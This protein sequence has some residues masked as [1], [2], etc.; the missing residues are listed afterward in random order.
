MPQLSKVFDF[1]EQYK[2][3]EVGVNA[4]V[5]KFGPRLVKT[6]GRHGDLQDSKTG[7]IIEVKTDTYDML[8]TPNFIMEHKT[9]SSNKPGGPWQALADGCHYFLYYFISNK[10][11]YLFDTRQ[12]VEELEANRCFYESF[13]SQN[14]GWAVSNYKVRREELA[15]LVLREGCL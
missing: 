9:I 8:Q 13:T 3:G 7:R 2:V 15:N 6:D 11:Y 1:S 14:K 10:Y 12:L 4:L 5:S